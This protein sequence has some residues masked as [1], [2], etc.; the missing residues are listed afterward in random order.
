MKLNI[1]PTI[2]SIGISV[3]IAY[4]FYNF[5]N[6]LNKDVLTYGSFI[7][8]LITLIC[9]LGINFETPRTTINIKTISIIFFVMF[10]ISNFIFSYFDLSAP[11]YII[12]NGILF[13]IFALI[14]NSIYK[15]RE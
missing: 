5:H 8:S 10:L 13:M 6:S 2:I 1:I 4:G 11:I 7:L 15:A 3:L 14:F 12:V 9:S